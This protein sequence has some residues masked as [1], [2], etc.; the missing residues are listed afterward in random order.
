MCIKLNMNYIP[1]EILQHILSLSD[2][3]QQ[4]RLRQ[5]S[6]P[7][8]N[9]LEIHDFYNI[10]QKYLDI[11]SDQIIS[12]YPQITQLNAQSNPKITN[13][14]HLKRL[15]KL[16]ASGYDCGIGDSGIIYINPIQLD[17][18]DNHK[19]TNIGHMIKLEK[20]NASDRNCG[21]DDS[22]ISKL[23]LRK[24]NARNNQKITN[25]NHMTKLKKLQAGGWCG[26]GDSGIILV[27][28]RELD[29]I[30]NS[31]ITK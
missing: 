23:N 12:N 24:L 22:G 15:T 1:I 27:N 28:L 13:V 17:S 2:F 18:S 6:K 9:Y 19:I 10:N 3:I 5:V 26:I 31:K 29:A 8:Y 7:F 20:L 21:I 16:D 11:L 30:H 4:I 25:V 14:N